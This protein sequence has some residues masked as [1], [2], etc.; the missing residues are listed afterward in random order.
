M[1]KGECRVRRAFHP[2]FQV[3]VE[4]FQLCADLP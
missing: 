1:R 4:L 2:R 3:R